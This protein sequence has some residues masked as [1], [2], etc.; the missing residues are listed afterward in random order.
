MKKFW[1]LKK[2][3]RISPAD[4]FFIKGFIFLFL[5]GIAEWANINL[6]FAFDIYPSVKLDEGQW[7]SMIHLRCENNNGVDESR[8]CQRACDQNEHCTWPEP[9]CIS[10]AGHSS[11][12]LRALFTDFHEFFQIDDAEI[13]LIQ[14]LGSLS[15][16][17]Y[18]ILWPHHPFNFWASSSTN[19][20]D[21][22]FS[23]FCAKE[24]GGQKDP[25]ETTRTAFIALH[26]DLSGNID[27]YNHLIICR[28]PVREMIHSIHNVR[29]TPIK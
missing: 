14:A 3:R 21:L 19:E 17:K 10:C 29:I 25:I 5:L 24:T 20:T 27:P 23:T 1:S 12:I 16:D 26:L 15:M 13:P 2:R 28:D 11:N 22:L 8:F 7:F 18:I 6:T 9:F 4:K